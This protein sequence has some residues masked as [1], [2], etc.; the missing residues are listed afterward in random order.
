MSK[1][2]HTPGPWR[3]YDIFS[4]AYQEVFGPK[5]PGNDRLQVDGKADAEL[6]AAAP[7]LLELLRDLH[8]FCG[9]LAGM[10]RSENLYATEAKRRTAELLERLGG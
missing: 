8:D 7:E 4:E 1:A 2:K 5:T 10:S 9:P 6:I 3:T